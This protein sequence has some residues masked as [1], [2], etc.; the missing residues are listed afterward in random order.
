MPDSK[1]D[2]PRRQFLKSACSACI[3]SY[4]TLQIGCKKGEKAPDEPVSQS[5]KPAA[6]LIAMC[7]LDCAKCEAYLATQK[8]DLAEKE[9]VAKSWSQIY[10]AEFTPESITCDGCPPDG[11][12]LSSYAQELCKIRKCAKS[13][14]LQNC[15]HC[16]QYPCQDLLDFFNM[17]TEAK[18][19]LEKIRKSI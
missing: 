4:L 2:N 6:S 11:K 7:G 13:K 8:D 5:G 9:R 19:N 18:T 14:G 3:L 12:R 17:A 16:P 1:S 10:G 15:A